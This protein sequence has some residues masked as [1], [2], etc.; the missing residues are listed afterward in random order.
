MTVRYT[1][2]AA[3][4]VEALPPP[5]RR[6]ILDAADRFAAT[7]AGDVYALGGRWRGRFRLRTGSRRTIFRKEDDGIV[8]IR[9]LHRRE[10]Y[11]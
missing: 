11:R 1:R 2:R 9:V 5:D 3:K 6:R 10:A 7:G 4:D 8:V